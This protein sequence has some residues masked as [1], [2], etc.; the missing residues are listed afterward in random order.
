VQT[1][2]DG[3]Q[4]PLFDDHLPESRALNRTVIVTLAYERDSD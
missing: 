3:R 4:P 2:V 1:Q